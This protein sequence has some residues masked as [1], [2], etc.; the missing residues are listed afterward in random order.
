MTLL[1][2]HDPADGQM[3]IVGLMSG[4]GSNLRKIIECEKALQDARGIP[5]YHVTVIFSDTCDSNA[6]T[7]G[8]DH[9]IPVVMRDIRAYY[10]ARGKPRRDLEVRSEYDKETVKALSPHGA[11]VAAF[12]G[13]MSIATAPLIN[14]FLGV[15]VHPADL[16][17]TEDGCRKYAGGH[18]VRDAILAG[19]NELRSS[20]HL[21][22]E[23][24]DY[25]RL[26]MISPP[27]PVRQEESFKTADR[28]VMDEIANAYQNVLKER[29]DWVI[30]P[31]T[32]LY[33]AE[34]RYATD[35]KGLLHVDGKPIPQGLRLE[36]RT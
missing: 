7:I 26:L 16:S 11:T 14:A 25:G 36:E 4:S 19:E 22:E 31:R 3:R 9:D 23:Q 30:F 18:A 1:P 34:G 27:L 15:N 13:Y 10:A 6:A 28:R 12:A 17:I 20:T 24:V 33:I 21:I 2:L 5:P 35:E 8:K 32:L 29:G